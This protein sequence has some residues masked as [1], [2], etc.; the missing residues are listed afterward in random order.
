MTKKTKRY[1]DALFH[2]LFVYVIQRTT[3]ERN[4]NVMKNI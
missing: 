4:P 2:A 1:F 3:K